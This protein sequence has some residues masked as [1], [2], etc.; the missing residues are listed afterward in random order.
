[1]DA[2]ALNILRIGV[3][4]LG[5]LW[6]SRHR[7]ALE[8]L[9]DRCRVTALYDQVAQRAKV[10]AKR[11]GCLVSEGLNPLVDRDDVDAI[12]LLEPQWF[13]AYPIQLAAERGKPV[14]CVPPLF[15]GTPGDL[16]ALAAVVD[17]AKIPLMLELPRRFHPASVRLR[18][19][20]ETKLG[21]PRQVLGQVLLNGFDRY[22][23]PGPDTQVAPV[24]LLV[25][26]GGYLIDWCRHIFQ[27]E[28]ESIAAAEVDE[29]LDTTDH[30]ERNGNAFEEIVLRFPGG[31]VARLR[32]LNTNKVNV[33]AE[34]AQVPP[35]PG[36]RIDCE[37]GSAWLEAPNRLWWTDLEGTHNEPTSSEPELG[38]TLNDHF[39]RFVRGETTE[40]PTIRDAL[41]V[42]HWIRKLR[43]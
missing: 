39:F 3:I 40:T 43:S 10:E 22:E 5:R 9:R 26:P 19:L 4:G 41:A 16:E 13:G 15:G 6:A 29:A 36:F 23:Q 38:L 34:V 8:R 11:L 1:M 20:I 24:P 31:V 27:S 32:I 37:R 42:D 18:E 14:Y 12:Y 21:P 25:D 17:R 2:S 28:P 7:P 33:S 35:K 30:L